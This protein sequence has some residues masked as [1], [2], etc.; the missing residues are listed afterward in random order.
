MLLQ[1]DTPSGI[2]YK[3]AVFMTVVDLTVMNLD[4][5]TVVCLPA[6]DPITKGLNIDLATMDLEGRATVDFVDFSNVST[7][8]S[9]YSD[10]ALM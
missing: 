8:G 7:R 5:L 4:N 6:K 9:C 3:S 2:G 10:T 1:N